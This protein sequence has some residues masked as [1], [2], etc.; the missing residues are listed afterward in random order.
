MSRFF[1]GI[2]TAVAMILAGL[3]F[4]PR[5]GFM[6]VAADHGPSTIETQF[7][8]AAL[9]AA[10]DQL[11]QGLRNPMPATDDNLVEGVR[12]YKRHCALCHGG[13]EQPISQ[14]G[15]GFYP[16]APQFLSQTHRLSERENFYLTK[17][18]VRWTGMPGWSDVLSDDE[19]WKV[20]VFL[21]RMDDM[22]AAVRREW[23]STAGAPGL[24]PKRGD[25]QDEN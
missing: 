5:S 23:N 9:H 18:G 13:P 8:N 4:L 11:S 7:A 3:Y 1:A 12:I 20:S 6:Y 24:E 19:I 16:P 21:T 2:V 14:I 22:P 15:R 10:V 25:S 17:H